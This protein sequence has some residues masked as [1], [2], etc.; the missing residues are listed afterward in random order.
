MFLQENLSP[1]ENAYILWRGEGGES[2]APRE[3]HSAALRAA[4]LRAARS[5]LAQ[6]DE[7]IADWSQDAHDAATLVMR[8][9]DLADRFDAEGRVVP[10]EE[11]LHLRVSAAIQFYRSGRQ[12]VAASLLR[13]VRIPDDIGIRAII[14][15]VKDWILEGPLEAS[16]RSDSLQKAVRDEL[17]KREEQ[18][19]RTVALL[20]G[21]LVCQS[22]GKAG[23]ALLERDAT[24]WEEAAGDAGK[25]ADLLAEISI[26]G[27]RLV[28]ETF[29]ATLPAMWS[30]SI[31]KAVE[32]L[33]PNEVPP[34]ANSWAMHHVKSNRGFMFPS[35]HKAIVMERLLDRKVGLASLPTGAGKSFLGELRALQALAAQPDGLVL[36]VVPSRA[37]AAEKF[38]DFRD[39]FDFQDGPQA[40][41]LTGETSVDSSSAIRRH[42]IVVLTPEKLDALIR[43][44]EFE[45]RKPNALIVD[46]FHLIRARTR[47][48][49]L[50]L[51]IRR[52]RHLFPELHT[53]LISAIVRP[54]DLRR[55]AAWAG[56]ADPFESGWKPTP[57]KLGTVD[58]KARNLLIEFTDGTT[59]PVPMTGKWKAS[60]L[61][62]RRR[63]ITRE[64]G[65]LDQVL[66]FELSWRNPWS[67]KDNKLLE[68]AE[69]FM[70]EGIT[71]PPDFDAKLNQSLATELAALLGENEVLVKA[72]RKGISAHWS[73]L[74]YPA[75]KII[76]RAIRKKAL[77][78]VLATSTLAEGVNLPFRTVFVPRL[79]R[80][81]GPLD[82]GTFLNAIGRAGRP[83]FHPEG[84][85]VVG[86]ERPVATGDSAAR[87]LAV[88]Y[89]A[90][91]ADKI[92][93]LVSGALEIARDW[94]KQTGGGAR[95][96]ERTK[97]VST[98]RGKKVVHVELEADLESLFSAVISC[99]KEGLV[100]DVSGADMEEAILL[101]TQ[102]PDDEKALRTLLKW[103]RETLIDQKVVAESGGKLVLT[104]WGNI[105]YSTGLGPNSCLRLRTR[106][107]E[108]IKGGGFEAEPTSAMRPKTDKGR[109]DLDWFIAQ[110]AAPLEFRYEADD[111]GRDTMLMRNWIAGKDLRGAIEADTAFMESNGYKSRVRSYAQALTIVESRLCGQTAWLA[112]ALSKIAGFIQKGRAER[113][114]GVLQ[115]SCL[116]GAARPEHLDVLKADVSRQLLR[117]DVVMFPRIWELRG[118]NVS[119][120]DVRKACI[121]RGFSPR[122]M[123]DFPDALSSVMSYSRPDATG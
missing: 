12:G 53:L 29:A 117:D 99:L 33:W 114:L 70:E 76:E 17:R 122:L 72:F 112:M 8:V 41:Q 79:E 67:S 28:A 91:D 97:V 55:L 56:S 81:D 20:A 94:D 44:G 47:G 25:A 101:G 40:C 14:Q 118:R 100:N 35:Q 102:G 26:G 116:L 73:E 61:A 16:A 63:E 58:V 49:K 6:T 77:A 19:A 30:L 2:Q 93:A 51:V 69:E 13:T 120:D 90:L 42:G 62:G 27:A 64:L 87:E 31:W 15:P 5:V 105:V 37:L 95:E 68:A 106:L 82:R 96:F 34:L 10:T 111:L 22:V 80:L 38:Q 23:R 18:P 107:S 108:R 83:F 84:R 7:L 60:A 1:L 50:Q 4:G 66:Q 92:D 59:L 48:F 39:A 113:R 11:R 110:L 54:T 123:A 43:A 98:P 52:M 45:T 3:E 86:Y 104:D 9:V 119:P 65:R 103:M 24:L 71:L 32:A 57:Q 89:V 75:R 88:D 36:F 21:G 78:V 46:E 109:Q 85:I 74:P 121:E 115:E